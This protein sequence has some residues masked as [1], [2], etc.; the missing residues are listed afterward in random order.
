MVEK[1]LALDGGPAL[2]CPSHVDALRHIDGN[3]LVPR[4]DE[5]LSAI[6]GGAV[7]EVSATPSPFVL[8]PP[9]LGRVFALYDDKEYGWPEHIETTAVSSIADLT[10][11]HRQHPVV[12]RNGT[13]IAMSISRGE[14]EHLLKHR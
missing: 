3:E 13:P 8:G 6:E 4:L 5:V 10:P 9:S 7:F 11:R 2:W 1:D 14:Y 12:T